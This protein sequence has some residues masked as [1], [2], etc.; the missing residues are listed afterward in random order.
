[1]STKD[2]P[3]RYQIGILRGAG[4]R[5]RPRDYASAKER[6]A[7]LPPSP[8]QAELLTQ[9]GLEVPATR[10]A[11]SAAITAYEL[12]HPTWAAERRAA[13]SAK[14]Q[15]TRRA[16]GQGGA[17]PRYNDTLEGYHKA[18]VDLH[19][20]LAAS[21]PALNYLRGLALQLPRDSEPRV[22]TFNAMRQGLSVAEAGI[23]I[24]ALKAGSSS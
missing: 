7:R 1:M 21:K 22:A 2:R 19:G 10:T 11:A 12:A 17:T 3:S 13:R 15:A 4:C 24:D 6:I 9:L 18:G 8:G 5:I 14:G 20:H 23:R 16:R